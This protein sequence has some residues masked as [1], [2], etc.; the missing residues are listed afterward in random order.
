MALSADVYALFNSVAPRRRPGP[1]LT[2]ANLDPAFAGRQTSPTTRTPNTEL[3][4]PN[5]QP[6]RP[7]QMFTAFD[8][9]MMSRAIALA[10]KGRAI[11]SPNPFVGCVIVNQGR[12]V[13]EGFTQAGRRLH[14]GG[15][16]AG[17]RGSTHARRH[18]I[19]HAGAF[20]AKRPKMR[21]PAC[22][23]RW[24]RRAWRA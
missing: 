1:N 12:I 15:G 22:A 8:H 14:R 11:T 18:C 9:A 13:G 3:C 4:T 17:T 2:F 5:A 21:G 20:A 24:R 7:N 23:N 19:R 10:E 6:Q 16:G